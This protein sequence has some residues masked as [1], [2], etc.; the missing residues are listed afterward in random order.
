[1]HQMMQLYFVFIVFETNYDSGFIFRIFSIISII[2][3]YL[4][5]LVLDFHLTE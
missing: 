5:Y 4:N 3:T 1:M 2:F